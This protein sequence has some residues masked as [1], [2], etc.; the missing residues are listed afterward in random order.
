MVKLNLTPAQARLVIEALEL[1]ED[2]RVKRY[3]M[4]IGPAEREKISLE[5]T[6]IRAICCAAVHTLVE[7]NRKSPTTAALMAALGPC[8]K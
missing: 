7:I 6:H 1:L 2:Q 4:K 8:G 5:L 3:E